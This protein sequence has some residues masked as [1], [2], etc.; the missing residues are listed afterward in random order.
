MTAADAQGSYAFSTQLVDQAGNPSGAITLDGS[1]IDSVAPTALSPIVTPSAAK[2]G[3]T[4][5]ATFTASET[6][7]ADPA[8][9]LGGAPMT[10]DPSVSPPG[11]RAT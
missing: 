3:T 4:V 6:L 5:I 7:G 11:Y 10:L 8:L 2:R 9:T 1:T